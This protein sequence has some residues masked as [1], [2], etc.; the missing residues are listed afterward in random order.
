MIHC[1]LQAINRGGGEEREQSREAGERAERKRNVREI[2]YLLYIRN[3]R[4]ITINQNN[5]VKAINVS[6]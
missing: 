3:A 6:N 2:I 4:K 1:R 5:D